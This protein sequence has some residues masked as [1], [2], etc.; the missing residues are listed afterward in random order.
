MDLYPFA[1]FY[2]TYGLVP[3]P[4]LNKHPTIKWKPFIQTPPS[5]QDI[6]NW[7]ANPNTNN[8]HN[9]H[10]QQN[11]H[12]P[13]LMLITSRTTN[14]AIV[15]IDVKILNPLDPH[16]IIQK[17][18]LNDQAPLLSKTPS[19]GIHVWCQFPKHI[20]LPNSV[21]RLHPQ[22]DIRGE[23]GLIVAP[24]SKHYEFLPP[25][26]DVQLL[27]T[28]LENLT[29]FPQTLLNALRKA[30]HNT[31]NTPSKSKFTEEEWVQIL[32]QGVSFGSRN[33]TAAQIIGKLTHMFTKSFPNTPLTTHVPLIWEFT[34]FWNQKND[35]P[36]SEDELVTTFKSILSRI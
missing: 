12:S 20:N 31:T 24:P 4:A 10:N 28:K 29:P 3:I 26:D 30:P 19:G 18:Q 14:L 35:P 23:H 25:Y 32:T 15:D 13:Q 34:C 22:I 27:R 36:L 17:L 8:Q 1:E 33:T 11:T 9:Q 16:L 2:R 5:K 7:F 21:Q 6:I